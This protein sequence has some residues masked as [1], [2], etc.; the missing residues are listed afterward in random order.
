M[1][2]RTQADLKAY[3]DGELSLVAR[4]AVRLHLT[5]C[6]S[7][8]EEIT[9]MTQIAEDLRET[10]TEG[11]LD[12]DLRTK[13]L[14]ISAASEGMGVPPAPNS[15]GVGVDEAEGF[16]GS[17]RTPPELGVGGR[18]RPPLG[19]AIAGTALVAWFICYPLMHSQKSYMPDMMSSPAM[20]TASVPLRETQIKAFKRPPMPV[21][22]SNTPPPPKEMASQAQS[23]A[24]QV[25]ITSGTETRV[26][27]A[28]M[29]AAPSMPGALGS[30]RGGGVPLPVQTFDAAGNAA[31]PTAPDDS[32]RQVHKEASIGV[33]VPNPETT[34]DTVETMVR[35]TGGYVAANNLSTGDDQLKSAEMTVKVPVA[36][37]DTFLARVAKLGN[38]LSKNVTGEDITE[39]TSDADQ[40]ENVLED[41]VQ[42]S[43]A[44][45]KAL[46]T[47][48]KW[49]DEQASRDLR[50]Q[51]AQ[52][53]ARLVLLKRMATLGTITVDLSQTPPK[54]V[55]PPVTGGFLNGLKAN[56]HDA[57]QSL[58]SSASALVAL[59]IWLLAYAPIWLPLLLGGRYVMREYRK[60]QVA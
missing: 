47:K 24:P 35:E 32:L 3:L 59:G 53:R 57:L 14:R 43:E 30:V 58:V 45:L 4:L 40:T 37:F 55:T 28:A 18:K 25:H 44:R 54:A 38:V 39:Q 10:E 20:Q 34:S 36:Q 15:G 56:T 33:Q 22:L 9:Q 6:A 49:H 27:A 60:R 41:D 48:A 29:P 23:Y 50:I 21:A 11:A 42:K 1:N 13:L 8:R 26:A 2:D 12:P 5:H 51:L 52:S 31:A 19:W 46:G 16:P 17:S 7:C